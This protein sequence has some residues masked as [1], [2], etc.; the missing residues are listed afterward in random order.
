MDHEESATAEAGEILDR[1][2]FDPATSVL[3]RRQAE[4][5]VMRER[6]FTQTAIAEAL[7]TSR[8]N[9]ANIEATAAENVEKA[10]ETVRFVRAMGAPVQV[11]IPA[12]IDIYDVP[13]EVYEAC[14][15]ADIKVSYSA[16]ELMREVLDEASAVVSGRTVEAPLAVSV[17]EDGDLLIRRA[18]R[19]RE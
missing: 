1:V 12:G 4:V 10:E 2:G 3:T 18:D 9:V 14:N 6:G 19:D 13:D 15:R 7:G 16:P 8:P 5:L 17:D 11:S